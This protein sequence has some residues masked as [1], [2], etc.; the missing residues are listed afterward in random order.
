MVYFFVFTAFLIT[1][2]GLGQNYCLAQSKPTPHVQKKGRQPEAHPIK[3]LLHKQNQRH[4]LDLKYDKIKPNTV[5][6]N[7]KP[8]CT[9]ALTPPQ[10]QTSGEDIQVEIKVES[11]ASPLFYKLNQKVS[12]INVSGQVQVTAPVATK[13][14]DAYFQLG[15][16]YQGEF[17]P[18]FL[19]KNF[20][21]D[22]L[23]AVVSIDPTKGIG[24]IFFYEA[25]VD[26]INLNKTTNSKGVNLIFKTATH[27]KWQDPRNKKLGR[28]N[29]TIQP[30]DKNLLGLWLRSD[31]DDSKATFTTTIQQ[32]TIE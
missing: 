11:S 26:K 15:L 28:F 21:P 2:L 13:K 14:D 29:F 8:F 9:E 16:I 23:N 22:W 20:L 27:I 25:S 10:C 19:T 12:Q 24:D 5:S 1:N 3:Q 18:N 7:Q 6:F 30:Q 4:F 31:G 32:I 17:K